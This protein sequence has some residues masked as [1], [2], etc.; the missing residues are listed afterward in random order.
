MNA[1]LLPP[2]V[3]CAALNVGK[4]VEVVDPATY[5]SPLA[6]IA[7]AL[8]ASSPLPPRYV[9]Y[10]IEPSGSIF[11]TNASPV[12]WPEAVGLHACCNAFA[13]GKLFERVSPVTYALPAEST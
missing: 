6:S 3:G 1:S 4:S 13:V 12:H 10:T 11:A 8:P 2:R 5:T 9:E 7:M